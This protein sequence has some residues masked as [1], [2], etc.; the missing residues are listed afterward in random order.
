[1]KNCKERTQK[2]T[3]YIHILTHSSIRWGRTPRRNSYILFGTLWNMK[4]I[5]Q[6]W[7]K[8]RWLNDMF[9][10]IKAFGFI[11]FYLPVLHTT[12]TYWW[13]KA[14]V[15]YVPRANTH[16]LL[17][18]DHFIQA[19][20]FL[21][22]LF[23]HNFYL[24]MKKK[25]N[26]KTRRENRREEKKRSKSP[27]WSSPYSWGKN[28]IGEK[29]HMYPCSNGVIWHVVQAPATYIQTYM[30]CARFLSAGVHFFLI[31]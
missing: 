31:K 5:V 21:K 29:I 8:L 7:Y 11:K 2:T 18:N 9:Y 24:R 13:M 14:L 6:K 16:L 17:I 30:Y 22:G 3:Y 20:I 26:T 23:N 1:M 27:T 19:S 15:L 12:H 4:F 10:G 28:R 25:I